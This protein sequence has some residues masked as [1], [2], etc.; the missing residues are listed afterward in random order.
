M[1]AVDP[2]IGNSSWGIERG[3]GVSLCCEERPEEFH[4]RVV[5][6]FGEVWVEGT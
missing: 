4:R 2:V 5:L 1:E 6:T 3:K